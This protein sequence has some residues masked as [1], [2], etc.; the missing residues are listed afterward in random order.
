MD[1][2][3]S[4]PV[5]DVAALVSGAGDPRAAAA[6]IGAACREHGFFY[7]VNHGVS[8]PLQDRLEALARRFFAAELDTKMR[9]RMELGGRAWRGY[10]PVKGVE[11]AAKIAFRELDEEEFRIGDVDIR[12][13]SMNHPIRV[14]AYRFSRGNSSGVYTGDNEPYYDVLADERGA[15]DSGIHNRRQFFQECNDRVVQF[16]KGASLLVADADIKRAIPA[17]HKALFDA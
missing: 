15:A 8:Q 7:V 11:L 6:G 17:L 16:V 4:V 12:T 1:L 3:G 10:F 13:K 2:S 9:L 14:L 5:I